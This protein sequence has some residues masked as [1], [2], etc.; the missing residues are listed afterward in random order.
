MQKSTKKQVAIYIG[1]FQI[2][3]I[4]HDENIQHCIDNY[5]ETIVLV[6]SVNRRTSIIHPF[7]FNTI[8]KWINDY[9]PSVIVKPLKDYIYNETTWITQVEESVYSEFIGEDC[10]FTSNGLLVAKQKVGESFCHFCF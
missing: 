4:A 8:K 7:S 9:N 10:E 2:K 3:H 5:D 6:G 1:K